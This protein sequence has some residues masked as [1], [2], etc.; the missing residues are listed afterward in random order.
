[1]RSIPAQRLEEFRKTGGLSLARLAKIVRPN[2][3]TRK[4]VEASTIHKL[5]NDVIEFTM[6]WAERLGDALGRPPLDFFDAIPKP[7]PQVHAALERLM[8]MT[9]EQQQTAFQVIEGLAL[10]AF[11]NV[12]PIKSPG[13]IA[14]AT[15]TPTSPMGGQSPKPSTAKSAQKRPAAR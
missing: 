15:P 9:D 14:T 8:G 5:E 13:P 11:S 1:M 2:R 7:P 12:T 3:K 6:D 4:P 10:R